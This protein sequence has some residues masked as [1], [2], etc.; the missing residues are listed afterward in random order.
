MAMPSVLSQKSMRIRDIDPKKSP[1]YSPNLFRW[2]K[3]HCH[4]LSGGGVSDTVY[5]V[6]AGSQL[7]ENYGAGTLFVGSPYNQYDGDMDFSGERLIAVLCNGTSAKSFCFPGAMKSLEE[8]EGF[9]DQ[10]LKVGRCAIDREHRENFSRA[11]RYRQSEGVRECLWCG[12]KHHA[13][14]KIIAS[15]T[16]VFEPVV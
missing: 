1:A 13:V 5:R 7:A 11:D 2:M 9:W 8:I 12:A 6:K 10:Y 15:S 16:I 3:S 14:E 4:E